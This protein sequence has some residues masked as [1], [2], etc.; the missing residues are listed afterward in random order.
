[1]GVIITDD[2]CDLFL[3]TA[4][5]MSIRFNASEVRP[6]G[7]AAVG[8]IGIKLT[9]EAGRRDDVV[10]MEAL[11]SGDGTYVMTVTERGYGK[12]T[13][14]LEHPQQ[15]RAGQGVITIKTTERN[16][17]VA[18]AIVVK[19]GDQAMV[20]TD[21]GT[22]IRIN[23]DDVSEIGRNTQGV[24]ILNVDEGEKVISVVRI[25]E[26]AGVKSGSQVDGSPIPESQEGVPVEAQNG[27][28]DHDTDVPSSPTMSDDDDD[29]DEG[30]E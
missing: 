19:P 5:G 25:D 14:E 6:M 22:L 4:D 3:T 12:R 10:A 30:K 21:G 11:K 13:G 17:R 9:Q 18:G 23:A 7:R 28:A 20:I 1:I 16:G 15:G 8:V 2:Q 24:R 29:T 27:K 26:P